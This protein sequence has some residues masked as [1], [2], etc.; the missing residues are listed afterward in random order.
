VKEPKIAISLGDF[1]PIDLRVGTIEQ[2]GEINESNKRMKMPIDYRWISP[3]DH[4]WNQIG[5]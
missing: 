5:S 1:Y 2:I 3:P 4:F